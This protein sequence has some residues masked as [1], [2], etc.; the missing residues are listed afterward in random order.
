MGKQSCSFVTPSVKPL[1]QTL[2]CSPVPLA[3]LSLRL[4][5]LQAL[6]LLAQTGQVSDNGKAEV[7]PITCRY[8]TDGGRGAAVLFL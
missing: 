4:E 2:Q 3:A 7:H 1:L 6:W 8:V 5:V